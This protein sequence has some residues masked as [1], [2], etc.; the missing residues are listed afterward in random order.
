[1]NV[2]VQPRNQR[3]VVWPR[4]VAVARTR[5]IYDA[6]IPPFYRV[7]HRR[8][9][10][11]LGFVSPELISAIA[12]G[13]SLTAQTTTSIVQQAQARKDAKEQ[14]KKDKRARRRAKLAEKRAAAQAEREATREASRAMRSPAPLQPS[15][16]PVW[17]IPVGLFVAAISVVL[18]SRPGRSAA[19]RRSAAQHGSNYG[20]PIA[21]YPQRGASPSR[22]AA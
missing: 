18:I 13:A 10:A 20:Q 17:L 1:M 21:G 19:Q 9:N 4:A 3:H 22:V 5:S 2:R 11:Q 15:G 14:A 12:Q 16:F 7:S 8:L 6:C